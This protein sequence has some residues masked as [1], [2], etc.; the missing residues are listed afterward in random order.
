M[1]PPLATRRARITLLAVTPGHKAAAQQD[2]E[3]RGPSGEGAGERA[4]GWRDRR[5]A[6]GTPANGVTGAQ[7]PGAD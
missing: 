2:Q 4:P 3:P 5:A 7:S 6:T 1:F